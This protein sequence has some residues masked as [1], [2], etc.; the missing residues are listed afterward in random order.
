MDTI[1]VRPT[2]TIGGIGFV[3]SPRLLVAPKTHE[4]LARATRRIAGML[5]LRAR[6]ITIRLC[7]GRSHRVQTGHDCST[8]GDVVLDLT[9]DQ[10]WS[11]SLWSELLRARDLLSGAFPSM[12]VSARVSWVDLL[13]ALS[14]EGRLASR[15][16]RRAE[17]SAPSAVVARS[18]PE[19]VRKDLL[20]ALIWAGKQRGLSLRRNEAEGISSA[21]W[22]VDV[23]LQ[24]IITLGEKFGFRREGRLAAIP[25]PAKWPRRIPETPL[26]PTRSTD[27]PAV[28]GPQRL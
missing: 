26:E 1:V 23:T 3:L 10:Q 12:H 11:H 28:E 6:S 5:S 18:G 2:C 21:V 8:D 4:I 15:G 27:R 24:S 22:G 17:T 7:A 19:R 13:W 20:D 9:I 16:I 25:L 14:I